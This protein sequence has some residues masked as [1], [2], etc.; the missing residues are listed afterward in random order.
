[1]NEQSL[2][3]IIGKSITFAS[4]LLEAVKKLPRFEFS[5]KI[6]NRKTSLVRNQD[7][8]INSSSTDETACVEVVCSML[9]FEDL[10]DNGGTLGLKNK[11]VII[12]GDSNNNLI[13]SQR[14]K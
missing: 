8:S 10:S 1:M 5:W 14:I 3:L 6:T 2:A 12:V 9:N 11:M 7:N 4:K 13:Y